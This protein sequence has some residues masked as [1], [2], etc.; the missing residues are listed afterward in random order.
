MNIIYFQPAMPAYRLDFFRRLSSNYGPHLQVNYSPVDMGALTNTRQPEVWERRIGPMRQ[1]MRGIEWQVGALSVPIRRGDLVV[2]CG[3]PRT[4]TT[5]L[6]LI[7]ARIKGARTIWWGQYWSATTKSYR[8]RLRMRLADLADAILFYTDAEVER[9]HAD[10]WTHRGPVSALN[11]GLDLTEVRSLRV[12]YNPA[13][14]GRNLLFIGRITAKSQLSLMVS[15]LADSSMADTRLHVI[16][17]GSG[18]KALRAQAALMGV[19]DKVTWHGGTTDEVLIA[20]VANRCAAFVYPGQVGLSL[21]HA[22]GYGLPSVVHNNRLRQMPEIAAFEESETGS[23]FA[24]GSAASLAAAISGLLDASETRS[25]MSARSLK[26]TSDNYN[27]EQ[28]ARRCIS[29][30]DAI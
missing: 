22:M 19:A 11:N 12:S 21:I 2:I 7:K 29:F 18:E 9:F 23:I 20:E 17:T 26:V 27:T 8:H 13:D 14:R 28:M 25:R 3:A 4:L 16:G 6:L 5:L 15:A 30:M 10:G 24:E 1:P